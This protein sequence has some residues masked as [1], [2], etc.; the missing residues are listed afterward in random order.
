MADIYH[1]VGVKADT[2]DVYRALTTLN[3][4]SNWW[5]HTTGGNSEGDILSFHFGEH[6]VEMTIIQLVPD[7]KVR[8]KC[9]VDSGEWKNTYV[10]FE[11]VQTPEQVFIN[12]AHTGWAAQTELCT[13]CNTKWAVFLLSLKDY[14][15]RGKGKPFPHDIHINHI[16]F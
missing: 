15:E 13:H 14:L 3:G 9:T 2:T 6:T 10:T 8:W 4:L 11:L 5:T 12:F 7:S 16:D 1:Q